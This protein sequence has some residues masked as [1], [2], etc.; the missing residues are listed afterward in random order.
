[1]PDFDIDFC[2]NRRDEVI[3]YV[4]D[5]YGNDR[6]AQIVTF[7]QLLARG[8]IRDVGRVLEIPLKIVDKVAKMIPENPGM[9]LER[10]LR[11]DPDLEKTSSR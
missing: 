1:M 5:K 4:I 3:K 8:V 2:K 9:T 7:G 11:E 10:A 6:V